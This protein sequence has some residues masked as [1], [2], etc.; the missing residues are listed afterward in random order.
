MGKMV[1]RNID[2]LICSELWGTYHDRGAKA[3]NLRRPSARF[4][5]GGGKSGN[6]PGTVSTLFGGDALSCNASSCSLS[7]NSDKS[8]KGSDKS[9]KGSSIVDLELRL[10]NFIACFDAEDHSSVTIDDIAHPLSGDQSSFE[11]GKVPSEFVIPLTKF[12]DKY[13]GGSFSS[14]FADGKSVRQ[15]QILIKELGRVLYSMEVQEVK[16]EETFLIWRDACRDIISWGLDVHFMMD[17]L[18]QAARNFFGY[19]LKAAIASD[20]VVCIL[21][22]SWTPQSRAVQSLY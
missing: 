19:M 5:V 8:E 9:E 17:H 1:N 18:K 22:S 20:I 4:N 10:R 14:L 2:D 21:E 15:K 12:A 16:S 11:G 3:A 6:S 7:P 13:G